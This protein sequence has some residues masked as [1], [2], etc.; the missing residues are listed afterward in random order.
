MQAPLP[1]RSKGPSAIAAAVVGPGSGDDD[2]SAPRPESEPAAP[3]MSAAAAAFA[4]ELTVR[5]PNQ[6]AVD[7]V[8]AA[9][10]PPARRRLPRTA[11]L[12]GAVVVGAALIGGALLVV[13]AGGVRPSASVQGAV[14]DTTGGGGPYGSTPSGLGSAPP[15]VSPS[16]SGTS[17]S[18]RPSTTGSASTGATRTPAQ[19][20][21]SATQA[22][23]GNSAPTES[24][25]SDHSASCTPVAGSGPLTDYSACAAPG[26][27]TLQATFNTSQRYYHAFIN[28]DGN[29]ATGY[30]LPYPSPSALGADYMI[31]NG[32][33]YKS[34]STGWDWT[35]AAAGPRMTVSGA[36]RTWTLP[37]TGIGSP[38]GMQ[39]VEFH[40]GTDYTPVITFSPK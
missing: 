6:A 15:S 29:T 26:T 14:P 10:R 30:Q 33:L 23:G 11:L 8:R 2:D 34:L 25:S 38:T 12:V 28:T 7:R 16:A 39:W 3:P 21:P 19:A 31:E 1:R 4:A 17:A 27:V 35:E 13:R 37:L 32:V 5:P 36:T 40:A 24:G 18:T 9:L 22:A 20:Q